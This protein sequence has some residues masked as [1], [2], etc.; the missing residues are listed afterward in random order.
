MFC[1]IRWSNLP[2]NLWEEAYQKVK[3]PNFLQSFSY[4]WA[5][6]KLNSQKPR[7]GIIE[8]DGQDAGILQIL[9]VGIL[10]N[11]IHAVIID[12]APLW[13]DGYGSPAHL[14]AFL[15]TLRAE[16]PRRFGR[17]IRFIPEIRDSAAT[18]TLMKDAGFIHQ[19]ASSYQTLIL[20][21]NKPLDDL[22]ADFKKR[23]RN[24]LTKAEKQGLKVEWD[25]SGQ[26]LTS[27]LKA[28]IHDRAAKGYDGPSVKLIQELA[29]T[30]LPRREMLIGRALDKGQLIGAVLIFCHGR[31]ST[32]QIGWNTDLGREKGAHY[33]LL[34]DALKTLKTRNIHTFDLGGVNDDTAKN[35]KNFKEGMGGRLL[36][37]P[38]LY[39]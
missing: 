2:P 8:I 26:H 30:T 12:R 20:D 1:N 36:S 27:F 6:I 25:D 39:S 22:R 21:L 35:V 16:F 11:L 5:Q 3:N 14:A 15:K 19:P 4:G 29:K 9:E 38:G 18:Q 23:W 13:Y 34:W 31:G 24:A 37:L 32:Y 28:Y 7:Y 33:A 17:K 10:K